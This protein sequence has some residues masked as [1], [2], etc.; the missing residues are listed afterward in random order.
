ME[1]RDKCP[2]CG[3]E[4]WKEGSLVPKGVFW[5][6]Q[7]PEGDFFQMKQDTMRVLVCND[8]GYMELYAIKE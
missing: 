4:T 3:S 6:I 7:F 8:C 1:E 2:K 5:G